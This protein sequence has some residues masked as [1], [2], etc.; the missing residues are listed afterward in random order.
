MLGCLED[1]FLLLGLLPLSSNRQE[2]LQLEQVL[3][4]EQQLQLEQQ[5]QEQLVHLLLV[6]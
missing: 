2:Q 4:L 1:L 6:E 3:L 5:Q